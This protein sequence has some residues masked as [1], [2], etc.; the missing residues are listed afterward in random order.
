MTWMKASMIGLAAGAAAA[1]AAQRQRKK[2]HLDGKVVLI[3]GAS[4]GLGLELARA[5]A[6]EGARLALLARDAG[7]LEKA[8]A[9]LDRAHVITAECDVRDP[10]AVARAVRGI[11]DAEGSLDVL[12]NVAGI[13]DVAPFDHLE[14][15][16]FRDSLD[17]HLWGPLHLIQAAVPHMKPGGRIVN[18]SSIGGLVAIPHLL[19]YAA[20]KFALTGLSEGLHAELSLRGIR[21]TTVCPG[22]IRTGSHVNARFKGRRR[23]EFAWFAASA[24]FPLASMNARRAARK[25]VAACRA[26]TPF[27]ILTPQARALHLLHA[28]APN[29]TAAA[30]RLVARL[31]PAADAEEG[32]ARSKGWQS[33]SRFAPSLLTRLADGAIDRY[34]QLAGGPRAAYQ[35]KAAPR[36]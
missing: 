12:V 10:E 23:Q 31:L 18:V 11:A 30:M 14:E 4:R 26:G 27:L 29:G 13:I 22:L 33:T 15:A 28:L 36:R 6:R 9:E 19:S 21:V 24:G 1:A 3:T 25:I 17:T 32:N 2:I 35:R 20:G 16:D 34:N 7:E 8:R 5:F